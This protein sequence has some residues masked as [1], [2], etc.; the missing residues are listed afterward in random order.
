MAVV[1][2][3]TFIQFFFTLIFAG[4][5]YFFWGTLHS[6]SALLGG[7]ICAVANLFFA[8]KLFFGSRS[9]EPK[10]ILR[11]FYRSETMKFVFTIAMFI[12]V[13]KL[14]TIEFLP[15]ILAYS[16]AALLNWLCLPILK[17]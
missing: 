13:F 11:Q 10:Q 17:Y 7:L 4:V 1:T 8:S 9:K 5:V 14:V 16:F 2:K 15:F 12:V 3:L 6:F